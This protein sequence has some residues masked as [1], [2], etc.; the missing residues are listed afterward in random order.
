MHS[1]HVARPLIMELMNKYLHHEEKKNENEGN[2][3]CNVTLRKTAK[4][5]VN[6]T[7]I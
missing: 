4:G 2:N 1:A 3:E 6:H 5:W 7:E